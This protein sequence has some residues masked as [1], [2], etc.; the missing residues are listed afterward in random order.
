MDHHREINEQPEGRTLSKR[1]IWYAFARNT[2]KIIT[3]IPP[4]CRWS[5]D[6]PPKFHMS[7]NI[8]FAFASAFAVGN[9]YYSHPILNVLAH[10]FGIS[11]EDAARIPTLMQAGY[12]VGLFFLCPL[13]DLLR[14]RAFVLCL[15]LLTASLWYVESMCHL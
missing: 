12:A 7:L 3:W 11:Y 14:R 4:R 5:S 15:I 8:L 1:T 9:L 10:D 2:W 13:G 6:K